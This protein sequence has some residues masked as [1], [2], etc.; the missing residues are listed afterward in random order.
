MSSSFEQRASVICINV[1]LWLT[2][3]KRPESLIKVLLIPTDLPLSGY[4]A[5][6]LRVC[7]GLCNPSYWDGG[8]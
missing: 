3:T 8:I 1:T 7:C 4:L 5:S 6:R 2:L